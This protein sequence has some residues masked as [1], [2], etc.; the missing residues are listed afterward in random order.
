MKILYIATALLLTSSIG[1]AAEPSPHRI[2]ADSFRNPIPRR[3]TP[4]QF[5]T[6]CI[7]QATNTHAVVRGDLI[8][9]K[10]HFLSPEGPKLV[11]TSIVPKPAE[12]KV[13]QVVDETLFLA[14]PPA[15]GIPTVIAQITGKKEGDIFHDTLASSGQT[16]TTKFRI[17][18]LVKELTLDV[19]F[20]WRP[21]VPTEKQLLNA[22][23]NGTSFTVVM[24]SG[25]LNLSTLFNVTVK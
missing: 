21:E 25:P 20:P 19:C 7:A 17:G 23:S 15:A 18:E 5:K 6:H 2:A 11:F 3:I 12:Y 10:K 4:E 16:Y 22:F 1:T 13:V 8:L 9:I 14:S 24:P